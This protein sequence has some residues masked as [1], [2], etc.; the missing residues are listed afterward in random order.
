MWNN[1]HLDIFFLFPPTKVET[2]EIS[3]NVGDGDKIY[4]IL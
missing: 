2:K 3:R 4:R 1:P